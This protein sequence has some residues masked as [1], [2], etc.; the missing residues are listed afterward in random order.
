MPGIGLIAVSGIL[1]SFPSVSAL[2]TISLIAGILLF[3]AGLL[4]LAFASGRLVYL[5]IAISALLAGIISLVPR[6][7]P[8]L[9][10][11]PAAALA[12]ILVVGWKDLSRR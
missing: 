10:L 8:G 7:P 5:G 12:I 4:L 6:R 9:L 1:T 3:S 2:S 11:I